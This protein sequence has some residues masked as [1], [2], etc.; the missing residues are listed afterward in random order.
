MHKLDKIVAYLDQELK[1][2]QIPDYPGAIN[3][4]QLRGKKTINKVGAAVD[5]ALPVIEEAVKENVDLL[6]VHH[7]LFWGGAER[8]DGALYKKIKTAIDSGMAIY[9]SHIPLDI[10]NRFGN[11]VLFAKSIGLTKGIPF[12]DWQGIHTGLRFNVEMNRSTLLKKIEKT[13]Q[14]KIHIA[15]G[16]PAKIKKLGVITG[17]AGTYVDAVAKE[18]IDTFITGEGQH[19]TFTMAEE[20]GINLIYAG[21][22][23]TETFGVTSLA[24]HLAKKYK[25]KKQFIHHPTGL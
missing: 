20:L 21:H 15:P 8:I 17:G 23:A 11:N 7:G 2:K 1:I 9:S 14:N 12:L 6:L 18:G 22:Y 3:G 13:L 16:G 19:H 10:H 4:L 5:A 24:N 25:L